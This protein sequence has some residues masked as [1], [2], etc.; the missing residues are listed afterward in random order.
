M[1]SN[2][3]HH[4]RKLQTE[5]RKQDFVFSKEQQSQYDL[6]LQ[7]RRERVQHLYADGR[8]QKGAYKPVEDVI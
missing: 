4:L 6:L 2:I 7:A 1:T 5:W 8:V 3:L